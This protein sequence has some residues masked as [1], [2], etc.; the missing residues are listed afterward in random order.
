MN[1]DREKEEEGTKAHRGREE[2]RATP[3]GAFIWASTPK[4]GGL[5]KNPTPV[6]PLNRPPF[7]IPLQISHLNLHSWRPSTSPSKRGTHHFYYLLLTSTVPCTLP[8][9]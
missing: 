8:S 9:P 2:V 1:T 4:F 7:C 3:V 5:V 6:G